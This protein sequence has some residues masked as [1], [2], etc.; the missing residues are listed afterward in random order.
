MPTVEDVQKKAK[1]LMHSM[2][3]DWLD[4]RLDPD[5]TFEIRGNDDIT[6]TALNYMLLCGWVEKMAILPFTGDGVAISTWKFT[7]KGKELALSLLRGP[8]PKP[9]ITP[10]P[11]EGK[12]C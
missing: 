2:G 4:N 5:T 3:S 8:K 12:P 11:S 1:D 6:M 9:P 7:N 10:A